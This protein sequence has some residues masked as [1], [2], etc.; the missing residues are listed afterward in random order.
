MVL[1]KMAIFIVTLCQQIHIKMAAGHRNYDSSVPL[2]ENFI[3]HS[4]S[5]FVNQDARK[6]HVTAVVPTNVGVI[7]VRLSTEN[8]LRIHLTP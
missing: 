1:L 6:L 8:E 4:A 2:C 5:R 7:S 3:K